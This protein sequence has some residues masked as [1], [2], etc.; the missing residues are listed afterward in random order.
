MQNLPTKDS[1]SR[2]AKQEVV[3]FKQFGSAYPPLDSNLKKKL[4]TSSD[5]PTSVSRSPKGILEI[6]SLI[7]VQSKGCKRLQLSSITEDQLKCLIFVA[8]L[9]SPHDADIRTRLLSQ[10]K[11]D[12]ELTLQKLTTERQHLINLKAKAAMI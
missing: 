8:G 7:P 6:S 2:S 5:K 9:Q 11:Q 1:V 12:P 3:Q 10:I 4:Q